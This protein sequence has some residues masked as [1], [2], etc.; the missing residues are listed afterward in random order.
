[1][2]PIAIT[3]PTDFI[4]VVNV[5]EAPGNF[6]EREARNF[7]HDV[8]DRR[9]ERSGVAPPVMSLAISSSV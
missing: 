8:I 6:L 3:S 1:M 7:C 4:E 5:V 2:R 9:L